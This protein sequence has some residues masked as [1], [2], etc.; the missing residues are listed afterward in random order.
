MVKEHAG[1]INASSC[2][3]R[4]KNLKI[5]LNGPVN[6]FTLPLFDII[7]KLMK[8]NIYHSKAMQ[9]SHTACFGAFTLNY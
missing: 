8:S 6:H 2:N 7:Y 3:F 9:E 4:V 5:Q 1:I